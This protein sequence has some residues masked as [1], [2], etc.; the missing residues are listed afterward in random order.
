MRRRTWSTACAVLVGL[1]FAAPAPA[2]PFATHK[3]KP[4]TIVKVIAGKPSEFR[5]TLSR[6]AVKAGVITFKVMNRGTLSHDFKIGGKV[7]KLLK[8]GKSAI[9]KVKLRKGKAK[10]LCTVPG[11][12]A[13][14]MK[15]TLLVK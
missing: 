3:A 10:Y 9:L 11:H 1:A 15:G 12:A 6:K 4:A 14:G 8:P 2:A 5:F 13:A 7:T